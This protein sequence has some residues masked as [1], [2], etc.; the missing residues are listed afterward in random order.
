MGDL[1]LMRHRLRGVTVIT[2]GGELDL[3]TADELESFVRWAHRPG[4]Q[5]VLDL[6]GVGFLDCSGLR[7]LL[8]VHHEV[9]RNGGV[10]RLAAPQP[11]AGRILKITGVDRC[12]PV[13]A[14]R[15]E[16]VDTA[17]T[18]WEPPG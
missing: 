10:C 4:D 3:V 16:A 7:A 12:V 17:L 9:S 15:A 5:V 8:R 18:A 2:I 13:H 1:T 11:I 14:S 6:T